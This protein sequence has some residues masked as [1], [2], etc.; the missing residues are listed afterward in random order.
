MSLGMYVKQARGHAVFI[1]R[2]EGVYHSVI[3]LRGSVSGCGDLL[4]LDRLCGT[5]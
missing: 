5:L 3:L 4:R 2:L 1:M